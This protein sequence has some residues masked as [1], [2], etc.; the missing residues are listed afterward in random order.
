MNDLFFTLYPI[1]KKKITNKFEEKYLRAV[2]TIKDKH[3]LDDLMNSTDS[4]GNAIKLGDSLY[5]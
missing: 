4:V 5:S 3:Y 1:C 2:R